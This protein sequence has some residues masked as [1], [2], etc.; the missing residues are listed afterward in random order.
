MPRH[1]CILFEM[2]PT[3]DPHPPKVEGQDCVRLRR[4]LLGFL[5]GYSFESALA[6]LIVY[7]G[8]VAYSLGS[9]TPLSLTA[10]FCA[11]LFWSYVPSRAV[12]TEEWLDVGHRWG[13]LPAWRLRI[14]RSRVV[15]AERGKVVW[16]QGY[17][18]GIQLVLSDGTRVGLPLSAAMG[19]KRTR[20]WIDTID[21]WAQGVTGNEQQ[22]AGRED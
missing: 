11:V 1:W 22:P 12:L 6:P 15:T 9:L 16:G 14:E 2:R 3:T 5:A 4:D 17:A 20:V 19:P 21:A 18:K 10:V 7:S 8:Y 13:R